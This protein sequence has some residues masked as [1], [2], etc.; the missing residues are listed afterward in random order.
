MTQ[1]MSKYWRLL[2]YDLPL[3]FILFLTNWLPDN[4]PFLRLRGALAQPFFGT[5]G[6][7]FRLGRNVT[8][9]NPFRIHFGRDVYI[10]Y[11][12]WFLARDK[13]RIGN[14]VMFGP[15][16]VLSTGNHTR[17]DGSFRFGPIKYL[18][19]SISDGAWIG[20]HSTILGGASLGKGCLVGS[21]ACVTRG[22][23]PDNAFVAGVP[24]GLKQILE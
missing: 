9:Y 8:F 15:Y 7:N 21:N 18:P 10:A 2:R 24:A 12:C 17:L 16:V 19:I 3:H 1:K 22:N 4:A 13:I 23:V 5:C 6:S 20:A 11:G 14:E